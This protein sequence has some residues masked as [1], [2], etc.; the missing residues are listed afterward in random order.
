MDR[1]TAAVANPALLGKSIVLVGLMGAGKTTVGRRLAHALGRRFVDADDEI[2]IA[3]DMAIADLFDRYGEAEFR[4]GERRVIARLL[5]GPGIV[6]ATGGG[7]Y[8][9]DATRAL[10]GK[11]AVSIWLDGD[12]D[13]LAERVTRRDIR[14]LLR[15]HDPA[16]RLRELARLRNP[17]YA[18]ADIRV[19]SNLSPHD[20]AVAMILEELARWTA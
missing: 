20:R 18:E 8:I 7:A 13:I 3:G 2:E 9:D 11:K 15:G 19:T 10:I 4:E 12:I 17:V 14:P 5:D 16:E 1:A 6:L